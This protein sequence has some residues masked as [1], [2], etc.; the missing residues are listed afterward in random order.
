MGKEIE[1]KFLVKGDAWRSLGQGQLYKQ[2]FLSTV[3]ERVVRVRIVGDLATLTIKGVADGITRLE[4]EYNIPKED[5]EVFMNILCERP[6]IEKT[7][8]RIPMGDVV[9]E[10]DEFW[11]ENQGLI[12]AEVELTDV[13]Q[14]LKVPHWIGQEVSTDPRYSNSNLVHMPYSRW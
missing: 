5:A 12:L 9:W 6:I 11:G 10:V 7:R 8:Y 4:Y 3:K 2:G 14:E 13:D 1:R